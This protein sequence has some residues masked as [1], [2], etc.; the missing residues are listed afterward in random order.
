MKLFFRKLFTK[1][2]NIIR[3]SD[4]IIPQNARRLTEENSVI[5]TVLKQTKYTYMPILKKEYF[6]GLLLNNISNLQYQEVN[7]RTKIKYSIPML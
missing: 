4:D 7:S 1:V 6:N 2:K 3:K 5:N